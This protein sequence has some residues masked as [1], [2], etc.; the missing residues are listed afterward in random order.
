MFGNNSA[1]GLIVLSIQDLFNKLDDI[2]K[3]KEIVV[4]LSFIEVY[5]ENIRD[6]LNVKENKSLDIW[7]SNSML[8]HELL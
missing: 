1:P 3:I 4:K 8:A 5:N 2:I 7:Y 6:L